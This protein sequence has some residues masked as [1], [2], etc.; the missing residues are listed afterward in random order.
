VKTTLMNDEKRDKIVK[1]LLVRKPKG[2][3]GQG[4]TYNIVSYYCYDA[5]KNK[6]RVECNHPGWG[7]TDE[8][9]WDAGFRSESD[10]REYIFDKFYKSEDVKAQYY[11]TQGK[12]AG[13]T[14]KANRVWQRITRA[15]DRVR[16]SGAIPGLYRVRVDYDKDFY[17][18]GESSAEVN[19]LAELMLSPI[20]PD[21]SMAVY[22][23]D[24]ALP[25]DILDR[26]VPSF[27]K[28]KKDIESKKR[29]VE[30][31]LKNVEE[32]ESQAE[33]VKTLITQNL[34]VAMRAS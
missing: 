16:N 31:L 14:R 25:G 21:A 11:L 10:V 8:T 4:P 17:F 15:L 28:I 7:Y 19:S 20:Y 29:R 23:V 34:E 5:H 9:I 30:Q 33:Y 22:F 1:D 18:Y 6:N 12:R 3:A 32:M 27:D 26:N 24:R 2:E 13:V